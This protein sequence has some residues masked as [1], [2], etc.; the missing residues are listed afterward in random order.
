[1]ARLAEKLTRALE[2]LLGYLFLIIT[3]ATLVL[4]ILRYFFSTTIVGGQEFIVFCFI[5]TTAIGAAVLLAKGGHI[6]IEV[7]VAVLPPSARHW[8]RRMNYLLV[9]LLNGVLVVLS[10][11]WIQSVGQFPSPVLRIPQGIVLFSLPLGCGL[12]TLFAVWM[13]A[14]DPQRS[15]R[16]KEEGT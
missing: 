1:M 14:T 8:L 2:A 15:L 6:S 12:V 3:V 7:C 16:T 13:A 4:V 9:A 5:Y 10:V 11:P